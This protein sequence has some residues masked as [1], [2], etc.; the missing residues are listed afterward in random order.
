MALLQT[1]WFLST[2][3]QTPE[4]PTL[5]TAMAPSIL[6]H[7]LPRGSSGLRPVLTKTSSALLT[8]QTLSPPTEISLI[9]PSPP[10]QFPASGSRQTTVRSWVTAQSPPCLSP[11]TQ[12]AQHRT[13]LF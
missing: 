6:L 3:Q 10:S 4:G 5:T 8:A 9:L 2:A 12:L 7:S 11:E 1:V 13:G